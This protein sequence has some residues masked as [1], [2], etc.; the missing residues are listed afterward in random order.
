MLLVK[1]HIH[2]MQYD[3]LIKQYMATAFEGEF[4]KKRE[5]L[6]CPG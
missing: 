3:R 1:R 6:S 2:V 5:A 4:Q